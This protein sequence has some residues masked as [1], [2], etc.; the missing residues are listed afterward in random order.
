LSDA[1]AGTEVA[2]PAVPLVMGTTTP[3]VWFK[4]WPVPRQAELPFGQA[5]RNTPHVP[6]TCCTLPGTPLVTGNT[7]P[8]G[9]PGLSP[10]ATHAVADQQAIPDRLATPG[11]K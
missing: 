5:T 1:D 3:C 4:F 9:E 11:T 8:P 10:T 2:E 7:T 6:E